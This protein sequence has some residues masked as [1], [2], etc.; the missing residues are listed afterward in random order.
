MLLNEIIFDQNNFTRNM[1]NKVIKVTQNDFLTILILGPDITRKI[2]L[3]ELK[4]L[5]YTNTNNTILVL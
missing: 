5:T 4:K 3:N 2:K 1:I